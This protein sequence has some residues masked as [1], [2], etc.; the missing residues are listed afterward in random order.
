MGT[1]RTIHL[2]GTII[3][4]DLQTALPNV[5]QLA[6]EAIDRLKRYEQIFSANDADADLMQVNRLA[7]QKPVKVKPEL[8][9]LIQLGKAFSLSPDGYLN[10]AIGPLV[11]LWHIGFSDAR[12]PDDKSIQARLAL[13]DPRLIQLN[14]RDQTVMLAKAGME[15][16]LGALAKGYSADLIKDFLVRS[17]VTSA[18]INL[19][20][21]VVVIGGN[22]QRADGMWHVGLQD[23]HQ[24][25]GNYVRV[26]NLKNQ[27]IVT[28][29]IYERNLTSHGHFYHH[30]FNPAT[31]YPIQTVMASLSIISPR[32]VDGEI[33]TS[34]LF[35][36]SWSRIQKVVSALPDVQ[37]VA[38]QRDG[39][40]LSC[41]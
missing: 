41:E 35:G 37:A 34:M 2:M 36:Q 6:D 8:F 39:K 27:S 23:P 5:E 4:L 17:G 38:I 11:K 1:K 31:G 22:Q 10:I 29:G 40:I 25:L 28:S 18:V 7:G 16:D 15:I 19:G 21:N 24:P 32:S 13:T 33:W 9:K 20:G 3:T 12:V 14:E 26:L 30:I